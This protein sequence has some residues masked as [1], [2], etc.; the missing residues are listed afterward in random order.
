MAEHQVQCVYQYVASHKY[1]YV[2]ICIYVYMGALIL[3]GS[4]C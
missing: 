3:T 2:N 1:K 4:C